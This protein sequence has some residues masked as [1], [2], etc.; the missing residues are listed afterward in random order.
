MKDDGEK[1]PWQ[2][3]TV[4]F[5]YFGTAGIISTF[6]YMFLQQKVG[7]NLGMIGKV[8]AFGAVFSLA[9]QPDRDR[10]RGGDKFV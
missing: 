5:L 8:T 6:Y 10:D 1:I 4:T 3:K 9:S 2:Y 7:L